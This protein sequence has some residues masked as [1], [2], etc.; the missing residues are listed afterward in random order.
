MNHNLTAKRIHITGVVQGVGF[1]PFVYGLAT[2]YDLRGW[3]C[4]TSAGVDIEVAGPGDLL[5]QFV[6]AL[7]VEAPPLSHID[8]ITVNEIAGN[9]FASFEIRH[10]ASNPNDFLPIS[11]DITL[12]EDCRR[13]M[14]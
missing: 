3:V 8:A 7:T 4:N 6:T 10:S 12:C 11:P 5:D 1:R 2:R 14:F 13:E 9:G